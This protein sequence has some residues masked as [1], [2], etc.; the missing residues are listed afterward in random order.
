MPNVFL[1]YRRKD[2]GEVVGRIYD[3]LAARLPSGKVFRD[4]DTIP[5]GSSFPDV[6]NQAIARADVVFIVMGPDWASQ[7]DA[8]GSRRIDHGSDPVRLE[9]ET[10]LA[11]GKPI[12]PVLVRNASFPKEQDFPESVRALSKYNALPVR[13]DPDFHSDMQKLLGVLTD[14]TSD[15]L[16]GNQAKLAVEGG[17]LRIL[18][19]TG[20]HGGGMTAM[21]VKSM[22]SDGRAKQEREM[23][24]RLFKGLS[25]QYGYELVDQAGSKVMFPGG[26]LAASVDCKIDRGDV[27]DVLSIEGEFTT[28]SLW[29][30]LENLTKIGLPEKWKQSWAKQDAYECGIIFSEGALSLKDM[31][32][33]VQRDSRLE[34]VEADGMQLKAILAADGNNYG[35]TYARRSS[36]ATAGKMELRVSIE[37]AA[38]LQ[39]LFLLLGASVQAASL[40]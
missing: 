24:S 12:V 31:H 9:V 35:F 19:D 25:T 14:T 21:A 3:F 1:S 16:K 29:R 4:L 37:D 7:Q 36:S 20:N 13:P 32:R 6:I 34:L 33:I 2:S 5:F 26:S 18:Q 17:F 30:T 28:A 40:H 27:I 22:T 8:D 10:A 39:S 38:E 11:H 23:V 15:F